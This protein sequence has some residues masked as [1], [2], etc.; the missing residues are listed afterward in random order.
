MLFRSV[1]MERAFPDENYRAMVLDWW[2]DALKEAESGDGVVKDAEFHIVAKDGTLRVVVYNGYLAGN[3]LVLTLRD[4]TEQKNS[5]V[6]LETAYRTEAKLRSEAERIAQARSQFLAGVSHEIRTPISA[7]VNL[8]QSLI[9]ESEKHALPVDFHDHLE[10][11]RV[12]GQYLNLILTNLLD[13][14]AAESGHAPVRATTFYLRDWV[15][16]IGAI[17]EPIARARSAEIVW[18]LP[19]DDNE[20]FST[21]AVRLSQILLNLAHNAVKF[22]VKPGSRIWISVSTAGEGTLSLSVAD[23]GPGIPPEAMENLFKPFFSTKPGGSGLGLPTARKVLEAHGGFLDVQSQPGRG[24]C[25]TLRLPIRPPVI[26]KSG[27]A[28][29]EPVAAEVPLP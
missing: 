10:K 2:R 17:I 14:S 11:V 3:L 18:C 25:F 4:I 8:S 5:A 9:L 28:V 19:E 7:L 12:G 16:D 29:V 26:P 21:D 13:V 6:A 27:P 1:W 23:E 22:S 24:T 15:E 20:K